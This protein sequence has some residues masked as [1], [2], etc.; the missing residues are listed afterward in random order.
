VLHCTYHVGGSDC[1]IFFPESREDLTG[2]DEF[3]RRGDRP[4]GYDTESSGLDLFARDHRLRLAQFGDDREAWVLRADMFGADIAATLHSGRPLLAHNAPFDAMAAQV[5]LGV[6]AV[7]L[8][9][10]MR[11]TRIWAHLLDPRDERDGGVGLELKSLAVR[12]L[13]PRANEPQ[14]ELKAEFRKHK[15][16]IANGFARIPIDNEAYRRYAGMDPIL[17]VREAA[18]LG[19][20]VRR[21]GL[22]SLSTFEHELQIVLTILM[23]RGLLVDVAYA[24]ELQESLTAEAANYRLLARAQYGVENVYSGTQVAD[25]LI[26]AGE[27]LDAR[28][29]TGK[30]SV[31]AATLLPLADLD[32]DFERLGAR[33]PSLLADAVLRCKRAEKWCV[34]YAAAFLRLRDAGDRI[35]PSIGGLAARTGRMSVS[36]PP[37]QQLP[38]TDWRIRRAL[39]PDPGWAMV[40]A[41]FA[42]V[43]MRVL[44]ALAGERAMIEAISRGVDLHDFAA[45]RM[46]GAGFTKPQRKLAKRIGF[47]KVYGGGAVN[48]AHDTGLPLAIVR[49]AIDL[50]N[51]AFPGIGRYSKN[52]ERTART[53]GLEVV[54][55]WG[56]RL[57]LDPSR[58]YAATNYVVSSSARDLLAAAIMRAYNAGLSDYLLL[59]IHD[60]LLGQAPLGEAAELVDTLGNV[61]SSEFYGVPIAVDT[62]VY[63]ASWGAGYGAP[64]GAPCVSM[65]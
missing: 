24:T 36:A 13:D 53:S 63:G 54:T 32:K 49:A 23:C 57:P 4:L 62:Q 38:A 1:D 60:E 31:D 14:R 19:T 46:F 64:E 15:L 27:P 6:D 43:E 2:F 26:L 35:H 61:M 25:G 16:T 18:L 33:E 51:T 42:Q 65:A 29:P 47:A 9:G 22:E 48:L 30:F 44:A 3:L 40:S 39:I 7:A 5:H 11:D 55:P 17:T 21:A 56:R 59:P 52:L 37:L 50:Y 10:H 12:D 28:T 58:T 45:T 20:R 8:L 34:A 41:D